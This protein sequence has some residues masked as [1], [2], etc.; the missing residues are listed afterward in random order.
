VNKKRKTPDK[1]DSS[2]FDKP[3][4]GPEG[5]E[6]NPLE[7]R[8]E[9]DRELKARIAAYRASVGLPPSEYFTGDDEEIYLS[10][11]HGPVGDPANLDELAPR[12][13]APREC[14]DPDRRFL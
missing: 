14:P 13:F 1:H 10:R 8:R 3:F 6:G 12:R 4:V 7:N 2:V 5:R 11:E 9:A